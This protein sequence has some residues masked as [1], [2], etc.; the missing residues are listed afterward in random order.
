MIFNYKQYKVI[1]VRG[2]FRVNKNFLMVTCTN[3][4]SS[5][6]LKI[7]QN[8]SKLKLN[9]CKIENKSV[10]RI[11]KGSI[12]KTLLLM[13]NGPIYFL[14]NSDNLQMLQKSWLTDTF[15]PFVFNILMVKFN[16]KIY[17]TENLENLEDL[18]YTLN[19]LLF[20]QFNIAT[21]K[22]LYAL[23]SDLKVYS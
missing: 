8:L 22:R 16:N 23:F 9:Y 11:L 5:V 12:F 21:T 2:Y 6:W 14:K 1:K 19:V 18:N 15:E 7:K 10:T 17:S 13:I 20:Y 3:K 4:Q